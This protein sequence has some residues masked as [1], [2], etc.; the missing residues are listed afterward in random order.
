MLS[1]LISLGVG[2]LFGVGLSLTTS[3][4][5]AVYVLAA[6]VVFIVLYFILMR[7][8]MNKV[9]SL[10]ESAQKDLMANRSEKAIATI[11]LTQKKYGPWQ[12][13]ITKQM[14]AQIGMIH[15]LR[16]DFS[17]AFDYLKKG[18]VRHWMAMSMLGIIY[19]KRNK[20]K[21]MIATFEKAVTATRK[22]PLLWNL[23]AYCLEQAG[24]HDKAITV[25]NKGM[26]KVGGDERLQANLEAL[27][28]GKK[29]KMQVYGDAWY[30][31]HLEKTGAMVRKQTKMVQ[32]RRKIVRR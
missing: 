26:K 12:F 5:P 27:Q 16:R 6:S 19:L 21:D 13:Y 30:Q 25:M 28:N 2:A 4:H 7:Q 23:Y 24:E 9:N 3:L 14:D 22:E 10:V 17:K 31:F 15:Y 1:L 8:V 32:G 20:I 29:M 11:K 18:F